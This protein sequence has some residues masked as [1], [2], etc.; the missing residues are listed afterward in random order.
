MR[1]NNEWMRR[2]AEQRTR[3][4]ERIRALGGT[5]PKRWPWDYDTTARNLQ[6]IETLEDLEKEQL[7]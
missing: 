4:E 2:E 1:R 7:K 3:L 6:L 5:I